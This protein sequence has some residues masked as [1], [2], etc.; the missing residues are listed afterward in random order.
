MNPQWLSQ[1]PSLS[2]TLMKFG[3]FVAPL[4]NGAEFD[5]LQAVCK[6]LQSVDMAKPAD[7]LRG[8]IEIFHVLGEAAHHPNYRAR[9]VRLA[10]RIRHVS[11]FSHLYES[12]V[13]AFFKREYAAAIVL[14]LAAME[15]ALLSF[16]GWQIGS[17]R[18]PGHQRL[19]ALVRLSTLP[20]GSHPQEYQAHDM[21]RDVFAN[22]L[23]QWLYKHTNDADFGIS[24]LNRHYVLHGFEPGNFYRP[25]D[26][27]RM[28]LAFDIFIEWQAM[29]QRISDGSFIDDRDPWIAK[30]MEYFHALSEGDQTIR[31]TWKAERELLQDHPRYV[32]PTEEYD[33]ESARLSAMM[34][35]M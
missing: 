28:I 33:D 18:Q 5:R 27:H 8:E 20:P 26:V 2:I 13:F 3:W 31:Q 25:Q 29:S 35:A 1:F 4:I 12:A 32:A 24:V 6:R 10:M 11:E 19:L 22:F 34:E 14:M 16:S 15:G 9:F 7:V 17:G 23:E 21:Y 30:R